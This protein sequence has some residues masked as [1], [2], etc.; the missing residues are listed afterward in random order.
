LG[1]GVNAEKGREQLH[2]ALEMEPN[3]P[4]GNLW[5]GQGYL[6][7]PEDYGKAIFYLQKAAQLGMTFA[8]GWLGL[9]LA[10]AGK[11]DEAAKVLDQLDE[12]SR[13]RYVSPFQKA[14]IFLGLERLDEAYEQLELAYQAREPFLAFFL[15][16]WLPG[17]V[18]SDPRYIAILKKIGLD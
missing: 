14:L 16:D 13:Q 3:L 18:R 10:Q 7:P 6:T 17:S 9:A 4:M 2:K 11:K 5:L 12:I 8:L 15:V 1:F